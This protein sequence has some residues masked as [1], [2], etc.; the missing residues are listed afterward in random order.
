MH[1]H[2]E[3]ETRAI[4]F[5]RVILYNFFLLFAQMGFLGLVFSVDVVWGLWCGAF[6]EKMV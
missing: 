4:F 1:Y 3:S 2:Q 5:P 6:W